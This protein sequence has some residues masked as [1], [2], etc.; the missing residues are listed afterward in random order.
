M[1]LIVTD[2]GMESV[3]AA[4]PIHLEPLATQGWLVHSEGSGALAVWPHDLP[5]PP[6]SL[7]R[8]DGDV[9]AGERLRLLWTSNGRWFGWQDDAPPLGV[10]G[11]PMSTAQVAVVAG[12]HPDAARLHQALR[13]QP[14]RAAQ[15]APMLAG[16]LGLDRPMS[17]GLPLVRAV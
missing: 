17:V 5:A 13:R 15:L 6:P 4:D 8:S 11:G 12:G 2:H 7:P 1:A 10:H 14:A 16:V 3:T 9:A